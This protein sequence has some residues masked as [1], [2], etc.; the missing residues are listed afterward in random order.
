MRSS[1]RSKRADVHM[2]TVLIISGW[3]ALHLHIWFFFSFLK[4]EGHYSSWQL[5]SINV[6]Q[7][8]NFI[9]LQW[10]EINFLQ[11]EYMFFV[12]EPLLLEVSSCDWYPMRV[13][14]GRLKRS[15]YCCLKG[16]NNRYH[17]HNEQ[18][19]DRYQHI[20][21]KHQLNPAECLDHVSDCEIQWEELK[22]ISDDKGEISR[23]QE[24]NCATTIKTSQHANPQHL[25]WIYCS[26]TV[27]MIL[28]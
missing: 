27:N 18:K 28:W 13:L 17:C 3:R 5:K 16:K 24:K 1:L 11:T 14:I 22:F 4:K 15:L 8:W 7:I 20:Y 26:N 19:S 23:K 25:A 6:M 12:V 9:N 2:V 21:I 10:V